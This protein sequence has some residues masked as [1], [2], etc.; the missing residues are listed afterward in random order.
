MREVIEWRDLATKLDLEAARE[1]IIKWVAA[2]LVAQAGL[3]AALV[4]L[5]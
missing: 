4:K 1:G 3:V 2:L 5:L